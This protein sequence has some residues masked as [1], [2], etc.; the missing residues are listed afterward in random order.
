[1]QLIISNPY[2]PPYSTGGAEHSLEQLCLNLSNEGVRIDI[3]TPSFDIKDQREDINE[4]FRVNRFGTDVIIQA[5]QDSNIENYF[6]SREYHNKTVKS[7]RSLS[8]KKTIL[9]ANNAQCILPVAEASNKLSLPSI[10]IVRDA[11]Y[12][13][14]PGSCI[15]SRKP[16]N[17]VVCKGFTGQ[18]FCYL[19]SLQR[20]GAINRRAYPGIAFDSALLQIRRI[21]LRKRGLQSMDKIVAISEGIKNIFSANNVLHEKTRISVIHNFHTAID[22]VDPTAVAYFLKENSLDNCPYFLVAGK[23][24]YGKGS[25]LAFDAIQKL[26]SRL[27]FNAAKILFVGKGGGKYNSKHSVDHESI[28]Q[29]LLMGV[30]RKAVAL[31][32][33]GRCQEGLHR[34]MVDAVFYKKPIICTEAGGVA[35]GVVNDMNGYIVPCEDSNSLAEAMEK[36][37]SWDKEQYNQCAST[38]KKIFNQKFSSSVLQDKWTTLLGNCLK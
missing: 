6:F 10:A 1:M 20:N 18:F 17:T 4:N 13:C 9:I 11:Q 19:K 12:F 15:Q 36:I 21:K 28:S 2:F 14:M 35:T 33:P 37:L 3:V 25:D 32:V 22:P 31:I 30:L 16:V 5:G 38:S 7:I 23:K 8:Q 27:E 29:A 24:S 34:S 26:N